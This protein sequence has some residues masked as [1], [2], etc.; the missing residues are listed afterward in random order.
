MARKKG[1]G[2]FSKGKDA[3]G[4]YVWT[5]GLGKDGKTGRERHKVIKRRAM[6]PDDLANHDALLGVYENAVRG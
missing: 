3:E 6:D 4:F 1:E 5:L 2:T